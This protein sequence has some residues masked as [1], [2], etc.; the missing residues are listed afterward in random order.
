MTLGFWSPRVLVTDHQELIYEDA[1]DANNVAQKIFIIC[2]GLLISYWYNET[3][4][5]WY[6]ST[7]TWV[8]LYFGRLWLLISGQNV[9]CHE[10]A[11]TRAENH[12]LVSSATLSWFRGTTVERLT[13][14]SYAWVFT[15]ASK[16]D[17]GLCWSLTLHSI[18][19]QSYQCSL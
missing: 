6:S 1:K 19:W 4:S 9:R 14:P 13:D 17:R 3:F 7:T 5:C 2:I 11:N 8:R 12:D 16:P 15:T 18:C 10:K